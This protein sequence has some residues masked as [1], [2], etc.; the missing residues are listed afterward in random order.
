[1]KALL[2]CI[3]WSTFGQSAV[4]MGNFNRHMKLLLGWSCFQFLPRAG[5]ALPVVEPAVCLSAPYREFVRPAVSQISVMR[6]EQILLL[7]ARE[8]KTELQRTKCPGLLSCLHLKE[9]LYVNRSSR[10]GHTPM[11]PSRSPTMSPCI[12]FSRTQ[13]DRHRH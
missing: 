9:L 13:C 12:G 2:A 4:C 8:L 1:M 10:L 6:C 11:M 3:E 7:N 5:S